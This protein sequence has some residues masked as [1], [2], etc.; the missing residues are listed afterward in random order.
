MKAFF[1]FSCKEAC[2]VSAFIGS[3]LKESVDAARLLSRRKRFNLRLDQLSF[4]MLSM[5]TNLSLIRTNTQI[6]ERRSR[7]ESTYQ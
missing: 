3:L 1:L 7:D 4:S 5:L 6:Y 2:I